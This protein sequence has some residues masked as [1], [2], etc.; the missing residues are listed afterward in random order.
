MLSL[1][2][3]IFPQKL[4]ADRED[5]DN[6]RLVGRQALPFVASGERMVAGSLDESPACRIATARALHL[7]SG[8]F[9]TLSIN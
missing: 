8:R 6:L 1:L 9:A 3:V 5:L 2:F 7:N 4:L